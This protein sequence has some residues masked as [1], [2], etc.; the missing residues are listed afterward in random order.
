MAPADYI[1]RFKRAAGFLIL[2]VAVMLIPLMLRAQDAP[3]SI[4]LQMSLLMKVMS[5]DRNF[6]SRTG[7]VVVIGIVYQ[8]RFRTSYE[9]GQQAIRFIETH[10]AMTIGKKRVRAVGLDLDNLPAEALS[11]G[12]EISVLYI[13]PLR[14]YNI[15]DLVSMANTTGL[16]TVTGTPDYV[17]SGVAVGFD[18]IGDKPRIL[19]NLTSAK[20]EGCDFDSQLLKLSRVMR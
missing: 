17:E 15:E 2:T 7:D 8:G 6:S 16:V 19:I 11:R 3:L 20:A 14:S 1:H 5:F 13:S 9:T 10:P 4:D 18:L 12:G